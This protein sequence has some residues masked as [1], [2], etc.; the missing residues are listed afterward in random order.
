MAIKIF[1]V[2]L[3]AVFFIGCAPQAVMQTAEQIDALAIPP[4]AESNLFSPPKNGYARLIIYRD[5][6]T[7]LFMAR[8]DVYVKYYDGDRALCRIK[9]QSSCIVNIKANDVIALHYTGISETESP[10]GGNILFKPKN[11][12]IY[13]INLL[14]SQFGSGL[15][16][17]W[18]FNLTFR[19]KE[20]CLKEYKEVYKPSHREYQEK[21]F[22][23]LVKKG[24]KRAY[25]E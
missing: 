17:W 8:F 3:V 25:K 13:C 16:A 21:W 15:S 22:N 10:F 1:M 6:A 24:D 19:D 4:S 5:Y 18:S 11:Q 14:L 20:T 2:V 7:L 23:R 9:N 12:H